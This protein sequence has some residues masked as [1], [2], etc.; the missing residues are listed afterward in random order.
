MF[1]T[2]NLPQLFDLVI[3]LGFKIFKFVQIAI[4]SLFVKIASVTL[5]FK[6][7]LPQLFGNLL[8]RN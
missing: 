8:L 5:K 2:F 7:L 3:N 1:G 6:F 4:G